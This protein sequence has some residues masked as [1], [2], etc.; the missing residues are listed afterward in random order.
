M[1]FTKIGKNKEN[2]VKIKLQGIFDKNNIIMH[3]LAD[4]YS[5]RGVSIKAQPC[6]FV[7]FYNT[8]QGAMFEFKWT[9]DNGGFNSNAFSKSQYKSITEAYE[10]KAKYWVLI[11]SH[12]HKSMYFIDCLIFHHLYLTNKRQC[13]FTWEFLDRFK[14]VSLDQIPSIL[15]SNS[16]HSLEDFLRP[17]EEVLTK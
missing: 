2:E 9:A 7:I 8:N 13:N 3:Q 15:F 5:A 11:E 1:D 4:T 16:Q 14:L 10:K 17:L 12:E 6:D